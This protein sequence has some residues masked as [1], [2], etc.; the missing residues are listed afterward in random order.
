[1]SVEPTSAT[2]D[3]VVIGGG[4]VGSGV[5]RDAALRGLSCML[6]EKGDFCSGSSSRT[7]RILHG[8][9]SYLERGEFHLSLEN[10]HERDVLVRMAPHLTKPLPTLVPVY[11]RDTR[12]LWRIR[13]GLRLYDLVSLGK[14]SPLYE[15]LGPSGTLE[16][17][18]VLRTKALKGAGFFFD[19]QIPF[20]ERLVLENIFSTREHGGFCL[21]YHEVT[22]I[23]EEEGGLRVEFRDA[24]D[25]TVCHVLGRV[26]VN[27]TGAWADGVSDRYR[28]GLARKVR[29]TRGAHVVLSCTSDHAI[30]ASSRRDD[31]LFFVLP[32][33]GLTIVGRTRGP[34]GQGGGDVYPE[35]DEVEDLLE[36]LHGLMPGLADQADRPL[37]SYAGLHPLAAGGFRGRSALSRRHRLHREG[38][39]ARF[40]TIVGGSLTTYRRMAEETVDAACR[41]LNHPV[42]C[43]TDR[44]PFFGGGFKDRILFRESVMECT[45]R[46]PHLPREVLDHL[47]CLYGRRC[48]EVIAIGFEDEEWRQVVS[49]GYR[50]YKAQVL[51]AVRGEDAHHLDDVILRRLR[52]GSTA[53]RG[54]AGAEEVSRLMAQ[55]L[56]WDEATRRREIEAF[57]ERLAKERRFPAHAAAP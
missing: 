55:E 32:F 13:T 4:V 47:V 49:P 46:I 53:D 12:K 6:L 28:E 25:G 54:L 37:W 27:A 19:Y 8:G 36:T 31:R 35:E 9:L 24:L 39:E 3:L 45:Q 44:V 14:G 29:P 2:F 33:E 48:Y 23:G 43:S 40:L 20:P 26:V 5:A 11:H 34:W 21:N 56:G 18:P 38:S 16:R 15:V 52:M 22:G 41:L 7:S 1:V 17:A 30:F 10:L 51:Y 42:P 50:D 57:E